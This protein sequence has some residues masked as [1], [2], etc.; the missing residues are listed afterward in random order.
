MKTE[1]KLSEIRAD[2]AGNYILPFFWLHGES[3]DKLIEEI[4]AIY[5][6]GICSVCLE[7]RTHHD[8]GEDGWWRDLDI[9]MRE[10][11][12]REMT[13]WVLDDKHFP[14]GYANG[15]ISKKYRE[16][17]KWHIIEEHVDVIGPAKGTLLIEY[18]GANFDIKER[19]LFAV[20]ACKRKEHDEIMTDEIIDLTD[21]V[22][23]EFLYWDVPKGCY[24]IFMIYKTREGSTLQ[25]YIHMIDEN[26]V[27]VLIEAV[28]EPHYKRY[29]DEFGKTFAGFF[30]DEPCFG[31][32]IVNSFGV[33]LPLTE[34]T[35]GLPYQALPW[36]DD[37]IDMLISRL[38]NDAKKL[39]PALWYDIGGNTAAVRYAYM[40][41]ITSLYRD[42][43]NKRL[44]D[45]CRERGVQYIGHVIEEHC[46]SQGAGHYFR[47]VDGQDMSG[48]DLVLH[49][50]IP[51][52]NGFK[53]TA[54]G[55]GHIKDP[56]YFH[57]VLAKLGSSQ[58]HI[59]PLTKGR[60][61]CEI[62]GAYGWAEG[63]P[64]M[65]WLLDHMLVRGINHFVP[66]AFTPKFPDADCPPH[67]YAGGNNPQYRDFAS[68]MKYANK[69]CHLFN[70]GTH[71]ATAALLYH[72]DSY[73]CD[74]SAMNVSR[75]AKA[76]Y[77]NQID[78]DI[79][80]CDSLLD[81]AK[82]ERGKLT[83]NKEQY[84]CLVIPRLS[85][86]PEKVLEKIDEFS[87]E[88]LFVFV[89]ENCP[90]TLEGKKFMIQSAE[91]ATLM[92]LPN[93]IRECGFADI[94]LDKPFSSLRFYHYVHDETHY[95]MCFNE[96]LEPFK[97]KVYFPF[98]GD[99]VRLDILG[100]KE[101]NVSFSPC[102]NALE[103]APYESC[104]FAFNS[105]LNIPYECELVKAGE[106]HLVNFDIYIA[107]ASEYPQFKY[108]KTGELLNITDASVCPDFSGYIK[109]ETK[110][111][112]ENAKKYILELGEVGETAHIWV[113]GKYIGS[114]ICK[115]YSVDISS[116]VI[117][118]EN[119]LCV[120][121]A[122]SMAY[123]M[124]DILSTQLL[125]SASGLLGPVKIYLFE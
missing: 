56:D 2:K 64:M 66:H 53:H 121:V 45:W 72:M 47:S 43:F 42:C 117:N 15:L 38:G 87:K 118:G 59:Q 125:L 54:W 73:W 52:L 1:Q 67:F 9:I 84:H 34:K 12:K 110:F 106:Q 111:T 90:D 17:R 96:A 24:R 27:D 99:G 98:E 3:E 37:L 81:S 79:I 32:G 4:D 82:V 108:L 85:K 76:L 63:V 30:S 51:G 109:Y 68:L 8:F 46:L 89:V 40:D 49:Q 6:C 69:M 77:D 114:R 91:I 14:T 60:A 39:L 44:G 19:S 105:G 78:Y 29:K 113:N 22:K 116:A 11:K 62:F 7:S 75:P 103:L 31:N 70:D 119:I 97:G 101:E 10:A 25:N 21:H 20:I 86:L 115:P 102:G 41:I 100:E 107:T 48:I 122:N 50:I 95:V 57:Y 36:R 92:N 26:S 88:G 13:V 112:V 120:E 58:S 80:P 28:Y 83:I 23:G 55:S 124:K 16:R 65:K 104:V 33:S 71:I 35:P 123:R 94:S 5:K 93:K 61:M 18:S 74:S